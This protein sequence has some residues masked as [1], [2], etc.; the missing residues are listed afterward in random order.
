MPAIQPHNTEESNASVKIGLFVRLIQRFANLLPVRHILKKL[1][2]GNEAAYL[3]R[4]TIIRSRPFA[5]YLHHFVDRDQDTE[6]HDHPWHAVSWVMTGWYMERYL[7]ADLKTC[8]RKV[9]FFNRI[10]PNRFHMITEAKP[11]TW[12]LF[13]RFKKTKRWGFIGDIHDGQATYRPAVAEDISTGQHQH[14]EPGQ[15]VI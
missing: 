11:G 12:T 2:D 8:E 5:V 7:Q 9:R 1:P 14:P 13:I 15:H 4:Y 6:M 3:D 10:Q